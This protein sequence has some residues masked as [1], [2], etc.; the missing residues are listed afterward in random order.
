MAHS[1]VI[2]D[3]HLTV[4]AP[5]DLSKQEDTAIVRTR[6]GKSFL[7]RLNEAVAEVLRRYPSLK[8]MKL[9]IER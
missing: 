4:I 1:M 6:R 8:K 7:S 3:Y 2:E 9:S 5:N